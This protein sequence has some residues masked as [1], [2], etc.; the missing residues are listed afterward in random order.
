MSYAVPAAGKYLFIAG[1]EWS[2]YNNAAGLRQVSI[3]SGAVNGN[4]DRG[5]T[6]PAFGGGKDTYQ[7]VVWPIEFGGA[8]TVY[9]YAYQTSGA[10]I[11]CYPYV[12]VIRLT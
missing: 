9:V 2:D 1:I 3:M 11:N 4:R 8:T 5:T 6:T 10:S 7:Q 12:N